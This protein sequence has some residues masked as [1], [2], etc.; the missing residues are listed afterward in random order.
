[1]GSCVGLLWELSTIFLN[2]RSAPCLSNPKSKAPISNLS[3]SISLPLSFLPSI[4]VSLPNVPPIPVGQVVFARVQAEGGNAHDHQQPLA[5]SHLYHRARTRPHLTPP[6]GFRPCG[7]TSTG[8]I[9]ACG[10]RVAFPPRRRSHRLRYVLS[11]LSPTC[12]ATL[13]LRPPQHLC[14]GMPSLYDPRSHQH[15]LS[16][17]PVHGHPKKSHVVRVSMLTR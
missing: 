12:T 4:R 16:V 6:L 14:M 9:G 5:R 11:T 1:M 2:N 3:T 7:T 10:P 8:S 13:A 15:H 17:R